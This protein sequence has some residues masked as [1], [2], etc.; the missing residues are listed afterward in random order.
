MKHK[1]KYTASLL[2]A[3]ILMSETSCIMAQEYSRC[4]TL[5]SGRDT[6]SG[7][8]YYFTRSAEIRLL[9]PDP[10]TIFVYT[11]DGSNPQASSPIYSRPLL[12][13]STAELNYVS[14]EAGRK[15]T[16]CPSLRLRRIEGIE[17]ITLSAGNFT[18]T[19]GT[20]L[21]LF[22]TVRADKITLPSNLAQVTLLVN[23]G[24]MA[25]ADSIQLIFPQENFDDIRK[26]EVLLAD[27]G[28]NFYRPK[29]NIFKNAQILQQKSLMLFP[30]SQ[31]FR[32]LKITLHL[33]KAREGQSRLLPL[34]IIKIFTWYEK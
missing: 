20:L 16:R 10:E 34:E 5:V 28:K 12:L 25:R 7:N 9:A 30:G 26:I 4:A 22:D 11:L 21:G 33:R 29:N 31:A 24:V 14:I 2:L 19:N 17:S 6:L 8:I 18:M 27:E 23:R 32:Y 15:E 1:F 3:G 13:S